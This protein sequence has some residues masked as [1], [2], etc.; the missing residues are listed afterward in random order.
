MFLDSQIACSCFPRL[1]LGKSN[2]ITSAGVTGNF[3][4]NTTVIY[5]M[6]MVTFISQPKP[7]DK[8]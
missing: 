7:G 1:E 5:F 2:T 8:I 3:E 6:S 4:P